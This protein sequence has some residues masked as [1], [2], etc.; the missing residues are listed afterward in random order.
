ERLEDRGGG[1]H[2]GGERGRRAPRLERRKA[3]FERS[4]VGVRVA[5]V[6]V[7]AGERAVRR[8]L[9]G[10]GK[11]DGRGDRAGGR[12][13]LVAGVHGERLESHRGT[14]KWN[15][16][17][18]RYLTRKIAPTT[19][20]RAMATSRRRTVMSNRRLARCAASGR[21]RWRRRRATFLASDF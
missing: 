18:S 6:D 3:G 12:I 4:A 16:R 19:E 7:T 9:E 10:R 1:G 20:P 14:Q 2:P 8:A 17:V 15:D 13:G 5:G 11:M 21:S